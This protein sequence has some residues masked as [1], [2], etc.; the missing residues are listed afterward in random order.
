MYCIWS[1]T[2]VLETLPVF[3]LDSSCMLSSICSYPSCWRVKIYV[4]VGQARQHDLGARGE[5]CGGTRRGW[6]NGRICP[7]ASGFRNVERNVWNSR[8]KFVNQDGHYDRAELL[9]TV[10]KYMQGPQIWPYTDRHCKLHLRWY[11][12][13]LT[14]HTGNHAAIIRIYH[15]F[16]P[17]S[18]FWQ[19]TRD[20]CCV[21]H[22][23]D[24]DISVNWGKDSLQDGILDVVVCTHDHV[25]RTE[26]NAPLY[27]HTH[28]F[29]KKCHKAMLYLYNCTL[30]HSL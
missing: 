7:A 4:D 8:T 28:T 14:R 12:T 9:C 16:P 17:L 18:H 30:L 10:Y 25:S 5:V 13:P 29:F 2:R 6:N 23:S 19:Y 15:H 3:V 11:Y 22:W 26:W 20:L 1:F 24:C 21:P 27:T